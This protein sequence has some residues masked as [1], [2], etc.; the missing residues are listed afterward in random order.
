MC[1]ALE[2]LA[3]TEAGP[4]PARAATLLHAAR[5][6]REARDLP[7]RQRDASE[8]Q[9]LEATLDAEPDPDGSFAS[10]VAELTT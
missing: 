8:L 7:L 6:E 2:D 4:H 1:E 9:A 3:R 5:T 10:L